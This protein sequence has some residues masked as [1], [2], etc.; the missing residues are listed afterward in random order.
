MYHIDGKWVSICPDNN[1]ER[2]NTVTGKTEICRGFFCQV[3]ADS[4]LNEEVDY[5]CLA[6][7]HE[8]P[9][10]SEVS[11]MSGIESYFGTTMEKDGQDNEEE[12][13]EMIINIPLQGKA[14][15]LDAS[16]C[17]IVGVEYVPEATFL[18]LKRETLRDYPF[19]EKW[20]SK[21]G[22]NPDGTL[23]SL[24]VLNDRN[25]DGIVVHTSG[26]SYARYAAFLPGAKT[27]LSMYTYQCM[28]D[29]VHEMTNLVDRYA[30]LS[31]DCQ[32]D[33][34]FSIN[35]KDLEEAARFSYFNEGLFREMLSNRPEIEYV[36]LDYEGYCITVAP[37]FRVEI[38]ESTYKVLSQEDV[39]IICA[40]HF[41]FDHGSGGEE[42]D[43][44]GCLLKGLDLHAKQLN[45]APLRG[46]R[47]VNC[48]LED[49]GLCF[50][51]MTGAQFF[52]CRCAGLTAEEA[53][54]ED[55]QFISSD[56]HGAYFTHSD[57]TQMKI[58]DSDFSGASFQNCCID[59]ADFGDTELDE[60]QKRGCM[61]DRAE[62]EQASNLEIQPSM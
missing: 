54:L 25:D 15:S 4:Q 21:L 40:K 13:T 32:L 61:D 18:L 9:D 33:G 38:D 5:F 30:K 60:Q 16:K 19:L 2:D 27:L 22:G 31:V 6:I 39:D 3:Y 52:R 44:S 35:H 23:N 17:N 20:S 55:A 8:I 10:N 48:N 37:E 41:L 14:S 43:F 29:F 42:A 57:C 26:Y 11:I 45:G 24:L 46:A 59:N 12:D 53:L 49:C 36:D 51:D 58:R 7:G 62:W 1:I 47:F 34:E 50:S 56:F 28:E